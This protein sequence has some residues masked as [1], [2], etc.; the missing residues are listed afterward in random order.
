LFFSLR[1]FSDFRKK[2]K[3]A[4]IVEGQ[5]A[6]TIMNQQQKPVEDTNM[7]V[8]NTIYFMYIRIVYSQGYMFRPSPGHPQAL[9]ENIQDYIDF[10][11]KTHCGIPM[12]TTR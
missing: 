5:F 6:Q 2:I 7:S 12:R 11:T 3:I 1:D 9:K 4:L 10:F 8:Q